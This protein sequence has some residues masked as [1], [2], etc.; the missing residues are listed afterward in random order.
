MNQSSLDIINWQVYVMWLHFIFV[1]LI[2]FSI[3]AWLNT[4]IYN[5]LSEQAVLLRRTGQKYLRKREMRLGQSFIKLQ[6]SFKNIDCKYCVILVFCHIT[7]IRSSISYHFHYIIANWKI[8]WTII[9]FSLRPSQ[10]HN[11]SRLSYL[12]LA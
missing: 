1:I 3:L 9:I 7:R 11:R 8:C 2:P 10:S 4:S 6:K 5:K 12:P